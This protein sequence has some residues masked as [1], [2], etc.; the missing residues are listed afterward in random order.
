MGNKFSYFKNQGIIFSLIFSVSL[1]LV[2]PQILNHSLVLGSDSLFHFNRVYDTY[3]QFKTGNFSYFQTNYGFQQG[4]RIVNALYGPGFAYLLGG[5]L[6]IV[7]S[8][9]KFQIISNFLIFFI[10][11][12]LM[13]ILSREMASTKRISLLTATFFMTSLWI[14]RWSTEQNF[15]AWGIALMP[16]VVVMALKMIKNNAEDLR[17]IPLALV[18][19]LMIQ[20]HLLSALMS[21]G[22]LIVFFIVGFIQ[23]NKKRQLV[24]K[25]IWA[26]LLSLVL[27]FNVWGA[28]LDVMTKNQLYPP[29]DNPDMAESTMNLSTGDPT[30]TQIGLVMSI[31]FV[32][33][34][35]WVFMKR[36]QLPLTNKVVTILGL[37][38][39]I[40]A[41][42]IMPWTELAAAVP[43][44]QRFLQFPR[45]FEGFASV[46]LL[47]GFGATLSTLPFKDSRKYCEFLLLAGSLSIGVQAYSE[48][49]KSNQIWNNQQPLASAENVNVVS[50]RSNKQIT[51]AFASSKLGAGLD[52]VTKATPDYLP[53]NRVTSIDP[54]VDYKRD[55][56]INKSKV[57][58]TVDKHG[59]LTIRWNAIKKGESISLPVVIYNG[60]TLKLNGKKINPKKIRLSTMGSPTIQSTNVDTNVLTV[61]YKSTMV[62]KLRLLIVVL[63]WVVSSLWAVGRMIVRCK[64]KLD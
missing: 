48:I 17:I 30:L 37:L 25:C 59:D 20:V 28:M 45:R 11:G 52:L 34:I 26:S 44:L 1:L 42:N 24:L 38:F 12:Y 62:T 36:D 6:L 22:V 64:N 23:T 16:L 57:N 7:H 35:L 49:N 33:Q 40:L 31:I 54:Y 19:S 10:S 3:M 2:L 18:V 55:M 21:I 14:T 8:W 32:L 60:S 13:Y 58:K 53:N 27:T 39:L 9:I 15:M 50:G 4:G 51:D 63:T 41:S 29:Y 61:G 46:L 47:A 5:L 43:E 56:I